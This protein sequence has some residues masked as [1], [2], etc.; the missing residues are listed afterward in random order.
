MEVQRCH[1]WSVLARQALL[2]ASLGKMT[3]L[4][5]H[6][7]AAE[8]LFDLLLSVLQLVLRQIAEKVPLLAA[9]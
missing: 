7:L 5:C 9:G 1:V 2:L 8:A 6:D 3:A 4:V